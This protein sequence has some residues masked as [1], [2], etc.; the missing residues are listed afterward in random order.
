MRLL[1]R[2]LLFLFLPF[3]LGAV[4]LLIVVGKN[5]EGTLRS[6]LTDRAQAT[7]ALQTRSIDTLFSTYREALRAIKNEK[8]ITGGR[9][10][11]MLPHMAEWQRHMPDADGIYFDDLAG[12]RYSASGKIAEVDNNPYL[13]R[14]RRGQPVI[15]PPLKSAFTGN[16]V[17]ALS[18]PVLGSEGKPMGAVSITIKLS[19][20]ES[21]LNTL[22]KQSKAL[23]ILT[24]PE[25]KIIVGLPGEPS[26][27]GHIPDERNSPL[28]ASI[29]R[30][31]SA[32]TPQ[33][34]SMHSPQGD[35]LWQVFH[36]SIPLT[37][38]NLALAYPEEETYASVRQM[39]NTGF[40]LIL[41]LALTAI[42]GILIFDISLL[43]PIYQLAAAHKRLEEGN[44]ATRLDST[45]K[46]EL[47]QLARSFNRMAERLEKALS[48][49]TLAE[50]KFR[51]IF[52]NAHDS[53][54]IFDGETIVDFNPA[55]NQIVGCTREELLNK[56]VFDISPE[57]QPDGRSSREYS[58]SMS[59][60][61]MSG[62][63]QSCLWRHLGFDGHVFDVESTMSRM[64][65][66][67]KIYVISIARD[68]TE[69]RK[70]E[71]TA[72]AME[73][74]FRRVFEASPDSMVIVRLTDGLIIEANHGFERITGHSRDEYLGKTMLELDIW[75]NPEER[76][77]L[78]ERMVAEGVVHNFPF[79]LRDRN[80]TPHEVMVSAGTFI[81][82]GVSHYVAI[83]RDVTEEKAIQRKLAASEAR[84]KAIF[85]AAP[86]PIALNRLSDYHYISVNPAHERL[87][88]GEIE[89]LKG[90]SVRE[91]GIVVLDG[92]RMR[93][94]TK[95][96][97][98]TGHL[99]NE[100]AEAIDKHGHR[101]SFVYSSRIIEIDGEKVVLSISTD[102]TRLKQVEEGLR[103]TEDA[104][105]ESEQRFFALFQ[106]SPA[107]L[108]VFHHGKHG[109]TALQLNQVW[110]KT[111]LYPEEEVI[112][113]D[114]R[115][116]HLWQDDADRQ[117]FIAQ[118][119][120]TGEVQEFEAW[121]HRYDGKEILC[122]I[123]GRLVSVGKHSLM[124][125][126]YADITQ[127]R[128][129][130]AA[131]HNFNI[132]LELR[133]QERTRE[134][135]QAQESLMHS[136]KLAALGAL[137][138]GVAHELSTPIGNSLVVATT[139]A[140]Q[141][142]SLQK[143][144][145]T[146]MKRSALERYLNDS[147]SGMTILA[148]NLQRATELI[149][150]FKSVA[151]DQTSTQR[152]EFAL[153]QIVEE[154]LTTMEPALKKKPYALKTEIDPALT[155]DSF[156]GPIEQVI[157]NLINN[158]ILHGFEGRQ[159]GTILIR[160]EANGDDRVRITVRDNGCGISSANLRR[161]F[162]PFF[163]TK[164]GKGGSGLGLHIVRNIVEDLLGGHISA[165]SEVGK[166]LDMI[167]DIPRH[168][169]EL[170]P[171]EE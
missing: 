67:G 62:E 56:S 6:D 42:A 94:Q 11:D 124:L 105:R 165:E 102:V 44:L 85:D 121:L 112:G 45:R 72:H 161:I 84:L 160:A 8:Q 123:S 147:G 33:P 159:E 109:Y 122:S 115:D 34:V 14:L 31:I 79:L 107:A 83:T 66:D 113:R 129:F 21:W 61:I 29:I 35:K 171:Q 74:K 37:G 136:E 82:S 9:I 108:A 149:Q 88:G 119:D 166:G 93:E 96:L 59:E 10:S 87:F 145:V 164:L 43:R 51:A 48:S 99:D 63:P 64:E 39:W 150:N 146:G 49:A 131:L 86:M 55:C 103:R 90:K 126:A 81:L 132:T 7:M 106:S 77:R 47:G 169:P 89:E 127:Q 133:I 80:R 78:A 134:L 118:I 18:E 100:E 23:A 54:C 143:M 53:I 91:A 30:S 162:D 158:A 58:A 28:T 168:A 65:I 2:L 50:Q 36:S 1:T 95:R 120:Q 157:I 32:G 26:N 125:V 60:R 17:V 27:F 170:P 116:F 4:L 98:E 97:I 110:F 75:D 117:H 155:M 73:E 140:E 40:W 130:E 70:A 152:R 38:W 104:L 144:L 13:E 101:V 69:S 114:T 163:T 22:S 151:V 111:F 41:G 68:V 135:Q 167:I 128:E 15:S 24:D 153:A 148:R 3:I 12:K 46:D 137:V 92:S 19:R 20:I 16:T 138:A 5:L 142:T 156:P 57:F 141:T 76:Q 154:I 139:L 71:E 52:E 25:G